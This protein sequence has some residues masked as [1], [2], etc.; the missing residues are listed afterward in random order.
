MSLQPGYVLVY[1][2]QTCFDNGGPSHEVYWE[3]SRA[4]IEADSDEEAIRAAKG[5][6]EKD[7][8]CKSYMCGNKG[9]K[10][11]VSFNHFKVTVKARE[12]SLK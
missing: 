9:Q 3:K 5:L 1:R 11:L 2:W 7:E 12:I 10:R 6:L 4:S 8:G